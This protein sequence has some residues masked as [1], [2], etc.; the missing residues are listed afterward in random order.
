MQVQKTPH[1][2]NTQRMALPADD[3]M[4]NDTSFNNYELGYIGSLQMTNHAAGR[5]REWEGMMNLMIQYAAESSL[6]T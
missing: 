2:L 6:A 4:S 5:V 3:I 1:M